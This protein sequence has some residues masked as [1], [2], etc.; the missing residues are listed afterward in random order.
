MLRAA[1]VMVTEHRIGVLLSK[2]VCHVQNLTCTMCQFIKAHMYNAALTSVLELILPTT[3]E[4]S[5]LS[6]PR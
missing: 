4:F 1:V 2:G 5:V 6:L 3:D